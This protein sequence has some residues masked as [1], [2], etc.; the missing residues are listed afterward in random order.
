[1]NSTEIVR[2]WKDEDYRLSL[3]AREQTLLPDSPVG[4]VALSDEELSEV[5]G[6]T[7][8]IL[9]GV[10]LVIGTVPVAIGTAVPVSSPIICLF[11]LDV[12]PI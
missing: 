9:L 2:S 8:G 4:I 5:G 12:R 7:T 10:P 1:M 11:P 3:G 6:G